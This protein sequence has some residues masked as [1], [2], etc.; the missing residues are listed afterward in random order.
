MDSHCDGCKESE[1]TETR[2]YSVWTCLFFEQ[3][4][5]N[6]LF[7]KFDLN[8]EFRKKRRKRQKKVC[9]PIIETTKSE[10]EKINK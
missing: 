10:E 8:Q 9:A 1:E 4:V 3:F 7:S 6:T 5:G 2:R